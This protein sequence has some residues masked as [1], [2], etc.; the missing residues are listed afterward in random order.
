MPRKTFNLPCF[1]R[2]SE[3]EPET[4]GEAVAEERSSVTESSYSSPFHIQ[5]QFFGAQENA[6][7]LF[8]VVLLIGINQPAIGQINL[9]PRRAGEGCVVGRYQDRQAVAVQMFQQGDDRFAGRAVEM[10]GGF[11]GQQ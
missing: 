11:V 3:I 8:K 4:G 1:P 9:T 2:L 10:A 7:V 5:H 6:N